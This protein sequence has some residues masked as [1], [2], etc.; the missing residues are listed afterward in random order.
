MAEQQRAASGAGVLV[1]RVGGAEVAVPAAQVA[2]VIRPRPLTRV[3][4]AP[5]ALLGVINLRGVVLPVVSLAHLLGHEAAASGTSVRIVVLAQVPAVGLL[6]EAVASLTAATDLVPLDL[7]PLL[8]GLQTAG[9]PPQ[10]RVAASPAAA[11]P[12]AAAPVA[13]L[14]ALVAFSVAGQDYALPLDKVVEVT[15]LPAA[16]AAAPRADAAMLGAMAFRGGLLPLASL[17]VLLGLPAAVADAAQARI[18]VTRIGGALVGLVADRLQAILR[19]EEGTLDPVPPLLT[20]AAGEARAAAICRLEGGRRLVSV[21]SPA[22]LFDT[23][24]MA[25][26]AAESGQGAQPMPVPEHRDAGAHYVIFRLAE[27]HYGLPIAA[28]DEVVRHPGNLARVPRA[29]AFVAGLLNLRGRA[30]PV[31]DQ[32]HRFAVPGQ[33]PARGGR[34]IV[35][36]LRGLQAGFAVDAVT[37]VLAIPAAALQPAP[38]LAADAGGSFSHV[39]SPDGDARLILLVDPQALLDKVER[40][41][42]AALAEAP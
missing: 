35:V 7:V 9:R 16:I 30:V 19:V 38:A 34:I 17:R 1:C 33:A 3:P 6:V 15:R 29:P 28:V 27:E 8:A 32:R 20:R 12:A 14:L 5:A 42:L 13:A 21:L 25:R 36:T 31:V 18:V 23:A 10:A 22:Q 4:L 11:S 26:F 39:A 37:D 40:D 2:E 41:L 24:T